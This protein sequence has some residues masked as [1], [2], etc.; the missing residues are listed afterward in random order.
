MTIAGWPHRAVV[1]WRHERH[2]AA[3]TTASTVTASSA[4]A[5]GTAATTAGDDRPSG[6]R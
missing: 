2:P 6:G 1:G 5:L 4:S 3:T